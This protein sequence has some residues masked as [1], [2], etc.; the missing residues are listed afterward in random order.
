MS[1][2]NDVL[3]AI[4]LRAHNEVLSGNVAGGC[5]GVFLEPTP[6]D[7]LERLGQQFDPVSFIVG[8]IEEASIEKAFV[9]LTAAYG[10]WGKA[11]A[12]PKEKRLNEGAEFYLEE[13]RQGL[14][15]ACRAVHIEIPVG[16]GTLY[17]FV[18]ASGPGAQKAASEIV[19]FGKQAFDQ[20]FAFTSFLNIL[21]GLKNNLGLG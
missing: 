9:Y 7:E 19:S 13:E 10:I 4:A 18:S 1:I 2:Q 17:F 16:S 14:F 12:A 11:M 6:D 20:Y 3:R 15:L 8:K 5:V 21:E